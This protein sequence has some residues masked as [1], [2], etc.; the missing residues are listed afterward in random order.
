MGMFC[1]VEDIWKEYSFSTMSRNVSAIC[2][3]QVT[4]LLMSLG[5]FD[6]HTG[7]NIDGFDGVHGGYGVGQR[8]LMGFMEVM[9]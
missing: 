9:V 3:V 1:K 8:N 7:R 5:H 2:I 6:G 4:Y